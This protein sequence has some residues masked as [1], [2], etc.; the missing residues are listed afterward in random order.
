MSASVPAAARI[1]FGPFTLKPS[2]IFHRTALSLCLVNLKPL[3]P[4]HVLVI[5]KRVVPKTTDLTPAE[6]TD[7]FQTVQVVQNALIKAYK[8]E[9]F[10]I[11][12]QDGPVAGQ[13]VPHVHVHVIPR[14]KGDVPEDAIFTML[15]SRD[16]DIGAQMGKK[17]EGVQKFPVFKEERRPRTDGE[18]GEEAKWLE[19]FFMGEAE[20]EKEPGHNHIKLNL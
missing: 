10:N 7:L 6:I 8:A 19:G 20:K 1:M 14:H 16:G 11:A 4:G 12:I 18:M 17:Q 5:P 3:L 15:E 13:T 9:G 2:Q